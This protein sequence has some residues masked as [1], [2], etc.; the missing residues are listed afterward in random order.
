MPRRTSIR[1]L[2]ALVVAA[3]AVLPLAGCGGGAA[4]TSAD[5]DLIVTYVNIAQRTDVY[6]N[7]MI[8]M[9]FSAPIAPETLSERTVRVLT[10]PNLQTPVTGALILDGEKVYFDPTRTQAQVD[11]SGPNSEMDHPFGFE[12]LMN[13]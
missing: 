10:G 13:H 3:V 9:R 8:E 11:R 1:V 12:A 5:D 2:S 4:G 7:Q 6:R